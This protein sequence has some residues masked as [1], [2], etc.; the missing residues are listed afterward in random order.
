MLKLLFI[1]PIIGFSTSASL[2]Q[3]NTAT[4]ILLRPQKIKEAC[5]DLEQGQKVQFQF[6]SEYPLDFN[7]HFHQGDQVDYPFKFQS[8]NNIDESFRAKVKATYC[9]MWHNT[10]AQKIKITYSYTIKNN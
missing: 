2:A 7:L 3:Q 1:A 9:L 6:S 4:G 5:F 10:S 8:I